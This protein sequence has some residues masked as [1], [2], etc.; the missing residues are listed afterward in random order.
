MRPQLERAQIAEAIGRG[1]FHADKPY[2]F[3]FDFSRSDR[4]VCTEVVYRS[5]EGIGGIQ[6]Q[7]TRRAGRLTLSAGDLLQKAM[8]ADGFEALAVF[9]PARS[10]EICVGSAALETLKAT[11]GRKRI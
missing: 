1:F 8:A 10:E 6:F 2:D 5:F 4:L 3:D 7:L 11:V 9:C